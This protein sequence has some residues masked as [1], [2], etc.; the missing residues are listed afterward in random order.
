MKKMSLDNG[1]VIRFHNKPNINVI[2]KALDLIKSV[3]CG[4]V[5]PRKLNNGKF[6]VLEMGRSMR[7]VIDGDRY[8]F[9]TH[10]EYNKFIDR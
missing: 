9:M 2:E 5:H 3:D 8:H 10:E 4:D 1:G 7:I 6:K